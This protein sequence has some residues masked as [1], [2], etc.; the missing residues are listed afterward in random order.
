M[1]VPP[2]SP[3]PATAACC[4]ESLTFLTRGWQ[5]NS[6][7]TCHFEPC[8]ITAA[9]CDRLR[10]T[11]SRY[12]PSPRESHA[13]RTDLVLLSMCRLRHTSGAAHR[14]FGSLP[15]LLEPI[16]ISGRYRHPGRPPGGEIASH[17]RSA[18]P[19]LSEF[20]LCPRTVGIASF[21]HSKSRAPQVR[22]ER[23]RCSE[24][25]ARTVARCPGPIERSLTGLPSPHWLDDVSVSMDR[26]LGVLIT[27]SRIFIRIGSARA[28]SK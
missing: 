21:L 15:R 26:M 16:A 23:N 7:P 14:S 12:R 8:I 6:Q 22:R 20:K 25:L 10:E 4:A 11:K 3:G 24:C 27:C 5:R 18:S 2:R 28:I 19:L 17:G 13:V 1:L 9:A